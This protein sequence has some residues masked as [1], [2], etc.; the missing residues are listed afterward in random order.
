MKYG[1]GQLRARAVNAP[2]VRMTG[3]QFAEEVF[4]ALDE[5]NPDAPRKK[6]P[7]ERIALEDMTLTAGIP[8]EEI[9]E[10]L[11]QGW[12]INAVVAEACY[13]YEVRKHAPH[14]L[15]SDPLPYE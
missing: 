1:P 4:D 3:G 6:Q 8:T 5:R 13:A 7:T 14:L 2:P 15:E 10:A 12:A 11:A 9:T